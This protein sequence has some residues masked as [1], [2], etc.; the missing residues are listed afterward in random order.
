MNTGTVIITAEEYRSLL[1]DSIKLEELKDYCTNSN[2]V[3]VS[4]IKQKL[5]IEEPQGKEKQEE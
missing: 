5:G 1:K 3:F 4:D 2:Y